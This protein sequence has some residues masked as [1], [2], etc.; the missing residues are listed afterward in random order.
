[1]KRVAFLIA[2][3]GFALFAARAW[4]EWMQPDPSYREAQF[5]AR[6][7]ARDTTGQG[8]NPAR[9]D[10]LAGQL[11]K[12]ARLPEA[13]GLYRRVIALDPAD[14]QAHAALGKL[15]LFR[16]QP[17][18]A[19]AML[20]KARAE[21]GVAE[22]L[23]AAKLRLGRYD[24]AATL[25]EDANESGRVDLLRALAETP[26]WVM[27]TVP[28]EV[29]VPWVRGHPVPLIRVKLNGQPVLM[30]IDTGA[31]DL[32][33]DPSA[34]RRFKVQT[35]AAQRREF[36]TGARLVVGNA[37]V[38]KLE[39]GGVTI[40]RVPAGVLPLRKWSI[41]V[42]PYGETVV[43]VIGLN[44]LRR[45]TPTLDFR[46]HELILRPAGAAFT[47]A[48]GAQRIP[49]EIWG[50][51]E[52]TVYGSVAGGRR[53]ALVVQSGVPGCGVGAPQEV[54]D[55]LGL[56]GGFMSKAASGVGKWL[57]GRPWVA[58][59]VPS[60]TIGPVGK[61]KLP[62]WSGALES[63]ELWRHGVRRDAIVGPEFFKDTRVTIDWTTRELIFES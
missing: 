7:A 25:A 15:A 4:S 13:E 34:A 27:N 10:S 46:E 48:A 40:E 38:Q 47:P 42:N 61:D 14:P 29:K 63:G 12:L 62:G 30:G 60:L 16:D 11:L 36:W 31:G 5:L 55:E 58:V 52:L 51:R 53:M 2:A 44:V 49:F 56:K 9:L 33:I 54:F 39:I 24:D 20:E 21:P 1:M 6:M 57:S 35:V 59:G 3:L 18:E 50:E 23:F 43:G 17:E 19:I 32:L 8:N 37:V 41:E 22:D 26:P 28:A 45:F